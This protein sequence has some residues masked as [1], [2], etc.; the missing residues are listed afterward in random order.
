MVK[1][2]GVVFKTGPDTA[3]VRSTRTN[4]CEHCA[5]KQTCQTLGGGKEIEVE[6]LNLVG[7]KTGDLVVLSFQSGSM[8]KLSFLIYVFPVLAMIGG[9]LLGHHAAPNY[10]MNESTASVI[11]CFLALAAAFLCVRLIGNRLSCNESYRPKIIRVSR[12]HEIES[13]QT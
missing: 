4:A 10:N 1:E 12:K 2:T 3:W 5:E 9:A 6:A 13:K 7:A 11:G 8:F